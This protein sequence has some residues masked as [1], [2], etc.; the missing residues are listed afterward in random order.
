M[1]YKSENQVTCTKIIF[2]NIN[3][4]METHS[5]I[6]DNIS[7]AIIFSTPEFIKHSAPFLHGKLIH[8][9]IYTYII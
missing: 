9:S 6:N 4:K 8:L 5:S 2:N 7:S 3:A 1:Y